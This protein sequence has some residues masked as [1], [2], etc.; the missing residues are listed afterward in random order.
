MWGNGG[1]YI[2]HCEPLCGLGE[3]HSSNESTHL[4]GETR[5]PYNDKNPYFVK[6]WD[7]SV[8]RNPVDQRA[9][10]GK[11][12]ELNLPVK[13]DR[14]LGGRQQ[15]WKGV[16]GKFSVLH[17]FL[18]FQAYSIY[19]GTCE[20]LVLGSQTDETDLVGKS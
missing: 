14:K 20:G 5:P 4:V 17:V 7:V 19:A 10:V 15:L 9:A 11:I 2:C 13:R 6:D 16:S 18:P 3:T 1:P 8:L 12:G